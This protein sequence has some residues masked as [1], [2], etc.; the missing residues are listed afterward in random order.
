MLAVLLNEVR[1]VQ[2]KAT[3]RSTFQPRRAVTT[4]AQSWF[5][6]SS[7]T[8][9]ISGTA[10]ALCALQFLGHSGLEWLL[11]DGAIGPENCPYFRPEIEDNRLD[12]R[13]ERGLEEFRLW[14]GWP[15]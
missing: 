12:L 9:L 3:R 2:K 15:D 13:G 5:V 14:A 10:G 6:A 8:N 11:L 4:G 7:L 1:T